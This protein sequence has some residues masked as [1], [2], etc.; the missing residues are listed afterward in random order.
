MDPMP[1]AS[2]CDR[3]GFRDQT[4][5]SVAGQ[6]CDFHADWGGREGP[7]SSGFEPR[8]GVEVSPELPEL[9]VRI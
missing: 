3:E 5:T 6:S 4:V 2:P 9:T 1:R 7:F 8:F